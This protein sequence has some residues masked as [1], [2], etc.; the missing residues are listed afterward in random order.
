MDELEAVEL[1][2]L[3]WRCRRGMQELDVLMLRY[4]DRR[5]AAADAAERADFQRLL[6]TED[7]RLWRWCMGREQCEDARLDALLKRIVSLAP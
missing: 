2:R 7:D 3:R 4:L 5:W 6:E 1:R